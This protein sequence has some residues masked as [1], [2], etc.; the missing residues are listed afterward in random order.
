MVRPCMTTDMFIMRAES[1]HGN[2][3]DYSKSVYVDYRTLLSITCKIHNH[4]FYQTP[5]N[6]IGKKRGCPICGGTKQKTT[7]EFIADAIAIHG[8][9]YDYSEVNYVSNK[10]KVRIICPVHGIFEQKPNDHLSG[11]GCVLC[12]HNSLRNV[13]L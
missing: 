9:V 4:L 11:S 13:P 2:K 8:N 10:I 7:K 5:D 1:I 6:H 12:Y 3:Y